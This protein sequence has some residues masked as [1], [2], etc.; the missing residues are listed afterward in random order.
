MTLVDVEAL[1]SVE[2]AYLLIDALT[3]TPVE[4][5]PD[6]AVLRQQ[7]A[8]LLPGLHA[9]LDSAREPPSND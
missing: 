6:L 4:D 3:K 7:L 8:D 1:D 5:W 2:T 9:V